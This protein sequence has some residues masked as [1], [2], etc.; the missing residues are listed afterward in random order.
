MNFLTDFFSAYLYSFLFFLALSLGSLCFLLM[1]FVLNTRWGLTIRRIA[2]AAAASIWLMAILFIPI[3]LG[4]KSLYPWTNASVVQSSAILQGKAWY[5]NTPFFLIRAVIYFVAWII[6]SRLVLRMSDRLSATLPNDEPLRRRISGLG[7]AGLIVYGLTMTFAAVDW[8]M[9][10]EPTWVSTI[11][12]M[13]VVVAQLLTAL[14]FGLLMINLLP[15]SSLGRRWDYKTTPVPFQDLGALL[16]VFVI[17]WAYLSYFQMLIQWGGN[18]PREVIWYA[19]RSTGGWQYVAIAIAILQ[20]ALPF[21]MLLSI[22]IRHNLRTLAGIA[23][24]LLFSNLL[25]FF[26]HVRPAFS[27]GVFSI[28]L[29]DIVVPIVMGAVWLAVFFFMLRRRPAVTVGEKIAMRAEGVEGK[30]SAIP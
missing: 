18:I 10:L 25:V 14:S 4:M 8:S 7:A 21:L 16:L 17:G 11:Y 26:W 19:A 28:S 27:P 9:S 13:V 5:L 3:V 20:F 6:L 24:M 30:E 29:W 15:G 22:R 23:A 2:G 1:H 12:G